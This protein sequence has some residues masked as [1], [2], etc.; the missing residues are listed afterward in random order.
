[1]WQRFNDKTRFGRMPAV[2]LTGIF[3]EDPA[4]QAFV[5]HE[6]VCFPHRALRKY[7]VTLCGLT[8]LSYLLGLRDPF[9]IQIG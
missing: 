2:T 9:A 1:M 8:N 5:Y 4:C 7:E 6:H 3:R